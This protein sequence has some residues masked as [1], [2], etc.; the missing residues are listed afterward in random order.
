[1]TDLMQPRHPGEV[2][3]EKILPALGVTIKEAAMQLGVT[4]VA[5]SRVLNGKAGI[6][7]EMALRLEKW[8]E[9]VYENQTD[10][11]VKEQALY[12]LWLVRKK[13]KSKVKVF[14]GLKLAA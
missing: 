6:S 7:P 8:L 1:M 5:L 3:R 4:R 14:N 2:I 12:D 9:C 11:W 13:F 10:L